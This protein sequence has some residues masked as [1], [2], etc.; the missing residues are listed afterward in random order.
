M[1]MSNHANH[2]L[3]PWHWGEGEDFVDEAQSD[4]W[5]TVAR[6]LESDGDAS[7]IADFLQHQTKPIAPG[8]AKVI[9]RLL[10]GEPF[11]R[12]DGWPLHVDGLKVLGPKCRAP[13]LD[14]AEK[15][16]RAVWLAE[17][18]I[19]QGVGKDTALKDA[20]KACGLTRI[21][22]IRVELDNWERWRTEE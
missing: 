6:S 4:H 14:K 22:E 15:L 21:A 10:G 12:E 2:P 9:G 11:P 8:L 3:A 19:K 16:R 13:D 5:A 20:A 7:A 1:A 17:E 18:A